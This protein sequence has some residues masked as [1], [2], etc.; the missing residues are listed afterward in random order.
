MAGAGITSAN[1]T[2]LFTNA[3]AGGAMTLVAQKGA[4]ADVA[5]GATLKS[6]ASFSLQGAEVLYTAT[7]QAGTPL[8]TSANNSAAYS[9]TASGRRRWCARRRCSARRR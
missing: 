5:D 3:F 7:L 6:F 9:A 4:V 2:A 1:S 8:V